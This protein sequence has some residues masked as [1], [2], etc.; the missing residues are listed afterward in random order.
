[1]LPTEPED[2]SPRANTEPLLSSLPDSNLDYHSQA[3]SIAD[4]QDLES[5]KANPKVITVSEESSQS[6][7]STQNTSLNIIQPAT[8]NNLGDTINLV[9]ASII[10]GIDFD[11]YPGYAYSNLTG[12]ARHRWI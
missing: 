4:T 11:K 6:N 9:P 12:R 10:N 5:T 1:M 7:S 2:K 8:S 3:Q